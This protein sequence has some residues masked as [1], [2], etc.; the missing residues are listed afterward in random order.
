MGDE[1][2][3]YVIGIKDLYDELRGLTST[4]TTYMARQD[5]EV[6]RLAHRVDE[7]ERDQADAKSAQIET[8]RLRAQDRRLILTALVLP[9]IVGVVVALIPIWIGP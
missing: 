7:L 2:Q 5:L 1:P 6:Q 4:L 9:L 8:A 3:G